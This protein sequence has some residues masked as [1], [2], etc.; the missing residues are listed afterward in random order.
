MYFIPGSIR[1]QVSPALRDKF[2]NA[3]DQQDQAAIRAIV[4]DLVGC[5]NFL[6]TTTCILLGLAPGSTY[7][8]AAETI[9]RK[10]STP[11]AEAWQ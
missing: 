1:R 5:A 9:T 6:P 11:P 8:D 4:R 10:Q 7:G 3:L 2:L